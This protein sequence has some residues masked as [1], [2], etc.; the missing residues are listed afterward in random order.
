MKNTLEIEKG[1][2]SV[3]NWIYAAQERGLIVLEAG[4]KSG[5][6]VVYQQFEIE[7][8]TLLKDLEFKLK[9]SKAT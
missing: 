6:S 1:K 9:K 5:S 8:D 3:R 7:G 2:I 4:Y